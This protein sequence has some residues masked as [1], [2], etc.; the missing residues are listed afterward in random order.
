MQE[1]K[2]QYTKLKHEK[3]RQDF[4][5]KRNAEVSNHGKD[6]INDARDNMSSLDSTQQRKANIK[7]LRY[8][9]N[10]QTIGLVTV[11][12]CLKKNIIA[13]ALRCDVYINIFIYQHNFLVVG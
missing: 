11:L 4:Y 1:I 9:L 7:S 3:E 10:L 5:R 8:F 6:Q 2:Y 13:N 12:D